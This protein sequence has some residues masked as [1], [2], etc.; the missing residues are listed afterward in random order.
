MELLKKVSERG[1]WVSEHLNLATDLQETHPDAAA[2]LYLKL[3]EAGHEVAQTNLA[4]LLD[5]S[6]TFLFHDEVPQ[7]QYAATEQQKNDNRV[8]AQRFYEMSADLGSV[9]SEL[10]LGDYAYYG[11]GVEAVPEKVIIRPP[12]ADAYWDDYYLK[13]A[14]HRL[15]QGTQYQ[16]QDASYESALAHYRRTV[17]M[18]ISA[19]WM[20]SFATRAAFNM[21]YMHQFGVGIHQDLTIAQRHYQ[22]CLEMEPSMIATPITIMLWLLQI[23]KSFLDLPP[24][25][26]VAGRVLEDLRVHAMV[27]LLIYAVALLHLRR[28]I[29]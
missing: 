8:Y 29:V 27:L 24:Y 14:E 1:P 20:Q 6:E 28:Q 7:G 4:H 3:A 13:E 2:Y 9:S 15:V 19:D 12:W 10:R 21:G 22:R 11:W 17:E 25:E 23:Q 18:N 16:Q 5:T 26:V